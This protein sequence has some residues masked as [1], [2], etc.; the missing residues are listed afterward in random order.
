MS[1]NSQDIVVNIKTEKVYSESGPEAAL[2]SSSNEATREVKIDPEMQRVVCL[3][4]D[5]IKKE[6]LGRTCK[7]C[8]QFTMVKNHKCRFRCK[9]CDKKLTTKRGLIK[10]LQ[11]VHQA[12]P[13]CD[14]F[15]CDFCGLRCLKKGKFMRHLKLKHKGGK[16]EEFHCDY[17]GRIFTS[18]LKIYCHMKASHRAAS[19]CKICGREVKHMTI[20]IKKFHLAEEITCKICFKTYKNKE[21]FAAHLKKQNK[22]FKCRLCGQKYPIASQLK[23]HMKI[24]KNSRAYQCKICLKSFKTS[25]SVTRH[26][27][28]HDQNRKKPHQCVHCDYKT[29]KKGSLKNHL[30]VHDKNRIKDLK[31]TKCDFATDSKHALQMHMEIHNPHRLKFSCLECDYVGYGDKYFK[32]HMQIHDKNREKNFKCPTCEKSFYDKYSLKK[33][34]KIHNENRAV[35]SCSQCNFKTTRNVYLK[36]HIAKMHDKKRELKI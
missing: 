10:H 33:H 5:E 8:G 22:Q 28:N 11:N 36:R 9:I 2:A 25:S 34:V 12:E 21:T 20:H 6:P 4:N 26:M 13:D 24:H 19:K 35:F 3:N 32:S 15:E 1:A 23:T 30:K 18:K 14:F 27:K 31:C 7:K 17:D 16:I 29:D